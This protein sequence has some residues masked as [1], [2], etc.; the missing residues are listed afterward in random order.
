MVTLEI[1][2]YGLDC[3][4]TAE[5]AGADRVELSAA[6]KEGGLTSSSGTLK[7]VRELLTIPVH[8]KVRPRGGDFCYS[9]SE[10]A[11]IK[12]D[13]AMIKE[14]G[15]PGIAIGM[16]DENAY[17]DMARMRKIMALCG[18]MEVTFH[19]A[20]DLCHN[21]KRAQKQ[22][23]ELGVARILTSGQQQSAESGIALLKELTDASEG[24]TIIAG[25]GI[26]LGNLQK[27]LD[28]GIVEMHSTARRLTASLMRYRKAGVT[29]CTNDET[30]EFSRYCV[31]ADVVE[32][33]KGIINR[34]VAR[35]A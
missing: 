18:R 26:Q 19:R 23:T 17:I 16:L 22:L 14:M 9:A 34:N 32:A 30:D 20:F 28:I 33:M 12:N 8:P 7:R 5:R 4:I 21:P 3:A 11:A 35:V 2:C 15:F 10:F 1:G 6:P 27:F 29:M 25:A 24:P 31:D 13:V